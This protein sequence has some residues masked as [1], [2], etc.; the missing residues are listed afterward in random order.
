MNRSLAAEHRRSGGFS[1]IELLTVLVLVAVMS[2]LAFPSMGGYVD[3]SHTRRALDRVVSD[4]T[5]ARILATQQGRRTAVTL[6]G[7]GTYTID[8]LTAEGAWAPV[9]TVRLRDDF[10]GVTL[11]GGLVTLEFSSRGILTNQAEDGFIK[12]HRNGARDS[13]FV[14]PAGRMY[15]GY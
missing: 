2:A 11:S 9:R 8:T 15:R 13:V 3:R 14:S 6:A 5:Y 7:D 12:I 1:T 10:G 4:V